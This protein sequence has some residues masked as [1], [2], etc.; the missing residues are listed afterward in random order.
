[1][2]LLKRIFGSTPPQKEC[3]R[4]LGKGHVDWDDIARLKQQLKWK[5]GPCAY[6][7]GSGKIDHRIEQNVPVDASYLVNDLTKDERKRIINGNPDA[8]EAGMRWNDLM[9]ASIQRICHMHFEDGLTSE[10]IVDFFLK[11]RPDG[12]DFNQQE[13]KDL[14]DYVERVIKHKSGKN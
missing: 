11:T 13:K 12:S 3:P 14:A 5:P 9:E 10:Q 1:M 7:N 6:C 2:N 4:C 8:I